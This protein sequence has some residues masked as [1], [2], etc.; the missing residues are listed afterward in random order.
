MSTEHLNISDFNHV[1]I[2]GVFDFDISRAASFGVSLDKPRFQNIIV[3]KEGNTLVAYRPW[4]DIIGWF[5]PWSRPSLKVQMPDIT[6]L[7]VSGACRGSLT[8]FKSSNNFKL[9]VRGATQLN[10]DV[11]AGDGKYDVDGACRIELSSSVKAFQ[12]KMA[13]ASNFRGTLKA[14]SGDIEIDGASSVTLSGDMGNAV[15][16]AAG[17]N[18]LDLKGLKVNNADIRLSGASQ[19]SVNAAGKLDADL[20]GACKLTYS[21]SPVMGNFKTVGASS[22]LHV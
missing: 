4:Y 3:I 11:A 1:R 16:R 12:L 22:L 5:N 20:S 10:G 8:G 18:H 19:C 7:D 2:S 6:G 14:D 15:I 21:G 9:S 13:G 17:A